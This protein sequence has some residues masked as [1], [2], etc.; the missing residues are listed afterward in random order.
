MNTFAIYD[1][2]IP[3]QLQSK[4]SES[5]EFKLLVKGRKVRGGFEVASLGY[6]NDLCRGSHSRQLLE[7]SVASGFESPLRWLQ[8]ASSL[9]G[10]H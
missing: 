9:R 1:R 8:E 2:D 5:A 6:C 3:F 4:V 7:A 10:V